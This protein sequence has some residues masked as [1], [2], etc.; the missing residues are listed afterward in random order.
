[1]AGDFPLLTFPATAADM[2]VQEADIDSLGLDLLVGP[3]EAAYCGW[4]AGA[5]E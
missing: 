1:V 2:L 5:V 4:V 3:F